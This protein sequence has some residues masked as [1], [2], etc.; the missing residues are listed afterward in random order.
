[1][2]PVKKDTDDSSQARRSRQRRML[3]AAAGL[4]AILAGAVGGMLF[5]RHR[6]R[7]SEA[8]STT[9]PT[10]ARPG[11]EIPAKSPLPEQPP[12]AKTPAKEEPKATL[13]IRPPQVAPAREITNSI[14]MKLVLI[15]AGKFVMG[16]PAR[17]AGR[18]SDEDREHEVEITRPFYMGV[19]EVTQKQYQE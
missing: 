2:P 10:V 11:P 13:P 15:P 12:Q 5:V 8:V 17:E 4:V 7:A 16:S 1:L 18:S 9:T 3:A 14:G 19:Y 6:D